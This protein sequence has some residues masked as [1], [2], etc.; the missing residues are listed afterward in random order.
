V[1]F[2]FAFRVVGAPGRGTAFRWAAQKT[3]AKNTVT[4][5]W[6][7]T[8]F[9]FPNGWDD[10]PIWLSY[11][12]RWLLH[13]Q[14]GDLFFHTLGIIVPFDFHIFQRGRYTT[15]QKV[16]RRI[17]Q[18]ARIRAKF[19]KNTG[20]SNFYSMCDEMFWI[21]LMVYICFWDVRFLELLDVAWNLSKRL[22][23]S[24]RSWHLNP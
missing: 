2:Q 11:F 17:Q 1:I 6:F 12:S 7:Q 10:D 16:R 15:N 3:R 21:H 23:P 13:H 8:F 19:K 5:W 18:P 4:G 22:S 9:I 24:R 20:N 14:P